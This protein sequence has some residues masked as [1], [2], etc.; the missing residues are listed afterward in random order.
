YNLT[1]YNHEIETF[2]GNTG[3]LVAWVRISSLSSTEDTILYMYYGN[4]NCGNQENVSGT[5]NSG[6]KMVHHLEETSGVHNDS[7]VYG[8]DGTANGGVDQD[9]TGRVDGCDRFDGIDD[10]VDCSTSSSLNISSQ[11]T[12]EA[13]VRDPVT[14]SLENQNTSMVR[15]IDKRKDLFQVFPNMVFNVKRRITAKPE[16]EV[17]FV[18][19]YTPGVTLLNMSVGGT[20]VFDG[21]Y[22]AGRPCSPLE[23]RIEN[24]REKLPVELRSREMIGY[25]QP[26]KVVDEATVNICFIKNDVYSAISRVFHERG[27]ISYLVFSYNNDNVFDFEC[28]THWNTFQLDLVDWWNPFSIFKGFIDLLSGRSDNNHQW[29]DRL[30]NN[31]SASKQNN[32]SE[33][34]NRI[35]VERGPNWNKYYNPANGEYIL[36]VYADRVNVLE[37]QHER[38]VPLNSSRLDYISSSDIAYQQGYRIGKT[39]KDGFGVYF[40]PDIC[41]NWTVAYS[42]GKKPS[43]VLLRSQLVG[44]GYL[45]PT[46]NWRHVLLEKT[47]HSRGWVH[48][49]SI[50]YSDVF[51]GVN[52]TWTY[53]G[54]MVKE[55]I[56]VSND[57]KKL[58]QTRPP[59]DFGLNNRETYLVFITKLDCRKDIYLCNETGCLDGNFTLYNGMYFVDKNGSIKFSLPPGE[60]YELH[61]RDNAKRLMYRIIQH[62][63]GYYVLMGVRLDELHNM[64]Y[65]MVFDPT[66]VF[67]SSSSDGYCYKYGTDYNAVRDATSGYKYDTSQYIIVGQRKSSSYYYMYRS[68]VYFNTSSLDDLAVITDAVLSLKCYLDYSTTDFSVVIQHNSTGARPSDPLDSTDYNRVYYSGDGGF[69]STSNYDDENYVDISMNTTGISWINKTGWTSCVSVATVIYQV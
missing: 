55:E 61:D 65:P 69:W 18:V 58:L 43:S 60:V 56:A 14:T 63:S 48:G 51:T 31:V 22:S 37:E 59:S 21:I 52:V 8:N 33:L 45:D 62:N 12:L 32:V 39:N 68:F 50:S 7:T 49:R 38:Y 6:Y 10:Y 5:W 1:K 15:I 40:K 26:F 44:I 36:E 42:Y 29:G 35:C 3:K 19:L 23:Y 30:E 64:R 47:R 27:E 16:G 66:M 41:D 57:T 25:S 67:Y 54:S 4:P 13:W 34:N 11:I 53:D 17:V 24:I 2:D 46:K 9:A 28:T 20:S